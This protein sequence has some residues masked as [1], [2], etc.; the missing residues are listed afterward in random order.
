MRVPA[1]HAPRAQHRFG[2]VLA[3]AASAFAFSPSA[4]VAD[5]ASPTTVQPSDVRVAVIIGN[6]VGL[7]EDD[8]LAYAEEDAERVREVLVDV[9]GVDASRIQLVKGGTAEQARRA[10]ERAVGRVSELARSGPTT[11][12]VYVSAHGDAESLHLDGTRLSIAELRAAVAAAPA[13]LRV[14]IIDACRTARLVT[15]KGGAPGAPVG[16]AVD[17]STAVRGDV[18]IRSAGAGEAAQEWSF[19]RGSL[20]THHL[21]AG[22][23]GAADID[24]DGRVSLSEAYTHAF[25]HTTI[26]AVESTG[27]PQHPSFDMTMSGFGDWTVAVPERLGAR[28]ELDRELAGHFWIADHA[29][30]LIAEIDKSAGEELA[31][32]VRPGWYRVVQ[33]DGA[34]ANVADINLGFSSRRHLVRADLART[35][36]RRATVRGGEPILLHRHRAG[37]GYDV[38]TGSVPGVGFEQGIG[39]TVERSFAGWLLRGRAR[40]S[41]GAVGLGEFG[42]RARVARLDA[43]VGDTFA[44]SIAELVLGLQATAAFVGEDV[45]RTNDSDIFRVLGATE[46]SRRTWLFGGGAFA[47]LWLPLGDRLS[48]GLDAMVGLLRVPLWSD[49]AAAVLEAGGRAAVAYSF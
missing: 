28:I 47:E 15:A 35:T 41:T 14:T 31:V 3:V 19:L 48:L 46:P 20:F 29:Y 1:R 24:H 38:S 37:V 7:A 42:G 49:Q 8:P 27:G 21:L 11:L 36:L 10:I 26:G 40:A 13:T 33:P 4:A 6:N 32:A 34:A 22:L 16:I 25:R 12:L 9:G 17:A 18:L 45:H 30:R 2:A 44:I 5:L 43:G 23:R 39:V